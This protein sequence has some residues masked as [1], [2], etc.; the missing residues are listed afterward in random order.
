MARG[1]LRKCKCCLKLFL[2]DPCNRRHQR[3][4]SAPRCR[5]ASKAA[6]QAR[7]LRKPENQDYFRDPWHAARVRT[8]RSLHLGAAGKVEHW[9]A[10]DLADLRRMGLLKPIVGGR[11]R[12]I[13]WKNADGGPTS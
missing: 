6:S 1:R 11:I 13:R 3:Y 12:A 4:C 10:I 8:W 2:P 5:R 9:R 7:W